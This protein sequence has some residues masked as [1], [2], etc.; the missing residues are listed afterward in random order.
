M[1][2][3]AG[4]SLKVRN[5]SANA[6]CSALRISGSHP[7]TSIEKQTNSKIKK[8]SPSA[9]RPSPIACVPFEQSLLQQGY[10]AVDESSWFLFRRCTYCALLLF[11]ER[12]SQNISLKTS[13]SNPI[14]QDGVYLLVEI[15]IK[16]VYDK[17]K[18]QVS[19]VEISSVEYL[20]TH[21]VT[22]EYHSVVNSEV[23][24]F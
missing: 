2:V 15:T 23:A 16:L 14:K 12:S 9:N 19:V 22:R 7:S 17:G 4:A 21:L 6:S 1:A 11:K 20:I 24:H 8:L 3:T 5:I 10:H 13:Q 18:H